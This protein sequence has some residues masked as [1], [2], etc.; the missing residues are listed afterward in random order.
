MSLEPRMIK[1]DL[2]TLGYLATSKWFDDR[3]IGASNA[4]KPA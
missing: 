3:L 1:K 4:I 2:V